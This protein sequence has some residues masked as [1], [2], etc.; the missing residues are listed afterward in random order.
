MMRHLKEKI[1]PGLCGSEEQKQIGL[2]DNGAAS[3]CEKQQRM[4]SFRLVL[5][6]HMFMLKDFFLS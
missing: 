3:K 2:T 1:Q 5:E 4:M 6:T